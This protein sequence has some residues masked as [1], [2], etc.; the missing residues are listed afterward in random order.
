MASPILPGSGLGSGLDIG[1]IV[2]ALVNSDKAAKQG[3]IT[4]QT[5]VTT[6]KISATGALKSA[7]AAFQTAM[8]GLSKTGTPSFSGFSATSSAPTTLTVTSD[9]TAV[10]GSYNVIVNNLATGSKV[11]SA[12]FSG[13]ASSA[14]PTGT[15]KISQNGI[16][17]PVTIPSGAT[18]QS[19]RDAINTTLQTQ[20]I[21]ANIVTDANGSRLVVGSTTTGAGSDISLSGIAGLEVNGT[22]KMDG[23]ATGAGFINNLAA[24]ASYSVDGLAMTSKSNTI[25][26]AVGGLNMTLLAAT[27]PNVPVVVTVGTNSDGLKANLQTFV[28]AYNKVINTLTSYTTPSL[29]SAGRPTVSNAMTGDSLPRNLIEAMRNQLT[30]VPSGSGGSPLAVLAQL[31]IQTDQ[32]TGALSIDS[33]KFTKA[34]ASGLSGSVQALFSGTTT[35]NGLI[36]RMSAAI[37]PYSQT[38]GILDQRTTSLNKTQRDLT[39]QQSALDLRVANLTA[40]LTAKYNAMDLLV[41]QMKATSTSITSFFTSLNAQKSGG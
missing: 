41:G 37:T 29:D 26:G 3:Q 7:L 13:G 30:N 16:D 31:G 22:T 6:S 28:D 32:K 24:S 20:G 34:M 38:G 17:Y 9:N 35:T 15:L 4:S 40:S 14:I 12:A 21:T 2:T 8:D 1:A 11:A 27:A 25:S 10:N 19:T 18:L 36:S 33:T 23:T 5:S 39:S